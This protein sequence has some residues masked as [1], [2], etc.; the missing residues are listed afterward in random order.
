M[1]FNFWNEFLYIFL[2]D[3]HLFKGRD[4]CDLTEIIVLAFKKAYPPED[5]SGAE[6]EAFLK[7]EILLR[8]FVLK[9][10]IDK[11]RYGSKLLNITKDSFK[12]V[13]LDFE[14][15][16]KPCLACDRGL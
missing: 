9:S 2:F 8:D 13:E 4:L 11:V 10:G 1:Y 15:L 3:V 7:H 5:S 6:I 16:D 12:I 14:A